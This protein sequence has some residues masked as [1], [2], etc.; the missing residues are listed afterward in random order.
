MQWRSARAWRAM[1]PLFVT[2]ILA[3]CSQE[4]LGTGPRLATLRSVAGDNQTAQIGALIPAPLVVQVVDQRGDPIEG[5][6]VVWAVTAGDGFVSPAVDTTDAQGFA[7]ATVRLGPEVGLQTVSAT[8]DGLAPVIFAINATSVPVAI[9]FETVSAAGRSSCGVD[10]GG[11]V[12]CWGF[13]GDGQMGIGEGP[14]GSGPV[15][16]F[17]Q[18]VTSVTTQ[19][20]KSLNGGQYHHCAVT[21]SHVGYC[22]GDNNNGQLGINQPTRSAFEPTLIS[23]GIPF[24]NISAGRAHSCGVTIGGRGWCWGSNERGQL[25]GS[26]DIDTTLGTV[27]LISTRAPA[28]VGSQIDGNFFGVFDFRAIAAGGVHTCAIEPS[29]QVRCWGMGREGQL[30]DGTNSVDEF[31]P[32]IVATATIMDSITAGYKHSC[33]LSTSGGAY[34]WGDNLYGQLGIGGTPSSNIPVAVSGGPFVQIS[35]GESHTCAIAAGGQAF[36]WG[37]NDHGQLGDGSTA[38]RSTPAAVAGGLIF[39]MISSGELSTCGVTVNKVAYCWGDNEYGALG[40]GT[41]VNRATPTKVQNQQ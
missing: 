7:S 39:K 4:D 9:V 13:N 19:S 17:P 32:R 10:E 37:R 26:V 2:M 29:G 6:L 5:H 30:G 15:Y 11:I 28:Q 20:F 27:D 1:A 34:C 41:Q 18:A 31:Q 25:G 21:F 40:D 23:V 24:A 12:F 33:S 14:A 22:W 16:T 35:A 38:S 36:C 8:I 3:S